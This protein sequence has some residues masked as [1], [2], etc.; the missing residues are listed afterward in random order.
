[1]TT[2][3]ITHNRSEPL[4]YPE[5]EVHLSWELPGK[6]VGYNDS[7]ITNATAGEPKVRKFID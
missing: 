7:Y 2:P 3:A 5:R 4:S 1:M 6:T